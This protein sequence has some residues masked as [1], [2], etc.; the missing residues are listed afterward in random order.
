MENTESCSYFNYNIKK[1]YI[2]DSNIRLEIETV[3]YK[4]Y[5]K[6]KKIHILNLNTF[7]FKKI[8][9]YKNSGITLFQQMP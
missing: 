5:L 7:Q 8:E 3:N 6:I 4:M 9:I 1:Q 2:F